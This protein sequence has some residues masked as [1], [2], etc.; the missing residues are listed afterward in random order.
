MS[1]PP[2]PTAAGFT[3][4]QIK[5]LLEAVVLTSLNPGADPKSW[6][7]SRHHYADFPESE[8]DNLAAL[9]FVVGIGQTTY[10]GNGGRQTDN[11]A[12]GP[13]RTLC[14]TQVRVKLATRARPSEVRADSTKHLKW[15]WAVLAA[16]MLPSTE[17]QSVYKTTAQSQSLSSGQILVTEHVIDVTHMLPLE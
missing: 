2:A 4:D 7:V 17:L 12:T 5:T 10:Q 16:L 15:A 1:T 13:R 6:K 9:S 3:P 8:T 14:R 11:R